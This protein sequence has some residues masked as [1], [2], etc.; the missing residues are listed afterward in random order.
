MSLCK[1]Y[2]L[3]SRY[4]S[5]V[6]VETRD[7]DRRTTDAAAAR[8]V[9]VS[10]PHGWSMF[11]ARTRVGMPF[12]GAVP[13]GA[14]H[15]RV[16]PAPA[17]P[18]MSST[19]P[20]AWGRKSV[21]AKSAGV[22]ASIGRAL[23]FGGSDG[24]E[25]AAEDGGDVLSIATFDAMPVQREERAT[26][27]GDPILDLLTTQRAS[28]LFSDGPGDAALTETIDVLARLVREG[29]TSGH[30]KYGE[31]IKRAIE[32]LLTLAVPSKVPAALVERA[33]AIAY[34]AASGG[35]TRGRVEKAI[36]AHAPSLRAR[37]ADDTAMRSSAGV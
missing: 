17:S 18:A 14:P 19:P 23:G 9:P 8:A 22:L 35:R 29:I 21:P 5:F 25:G 30:A 7:G 20:A 6:V 31:Q 15:S 32:A 24:S 27:D 28:G 4:T 36:D 34:L 11:D 10:A 26:R 12:G 16:M 13:Q 1:E 2:G 37:L 33:L 3:A